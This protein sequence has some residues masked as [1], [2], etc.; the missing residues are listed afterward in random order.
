[1]KR[2]H[3]FTLIELLVVIA[4]IAILAAM[5]FP[6]FAQAREKARQIACLSNLKQTGTAWMMYVQ[7]YDEY[8]PMGRGC[9]MFPRRAINQGGNC[10]CGNAPPFSDGTYA[11][12]S[13]LIQPY[14]KN[15]G[16][17]MCPSRVNE[18][19]DWQNPTATRD[20][21]VNRETLKVNYAVNYIAARGNCKPISAC[22]GGQGNFNYPW[23]P[24]CLF[25]RHWAGI[26]EPANLITII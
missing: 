6:V 17:Y 21:T 2:R 23:E 15:F 11:R 12:W 4:I 20:P 7:D 16:L 8:T 13:D 1:M 18:G 9:N 25:G 10:E 5:L 14:V 24:H 3:G 26:V 22:T 19:F